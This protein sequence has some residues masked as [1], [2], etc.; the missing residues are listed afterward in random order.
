MPASLQEFQL[1][2]KRDCQ[3]TDNERGTRSW[4]YFGISGQQ[5]VS[6]AP[7]AEGI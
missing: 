3:D 7:W 6:C 4:F 2:T 5:Q 1:W